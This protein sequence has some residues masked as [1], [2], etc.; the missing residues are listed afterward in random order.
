MVVSMMKKNEGGET[1]RKDRVK[2]VCVC[3]YVLV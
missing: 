1:G 2:C 3:V